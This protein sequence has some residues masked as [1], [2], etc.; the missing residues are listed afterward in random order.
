MSDK[1]QPKTFK[2]D[3]FIMG[4]GGISALISGGTLHPIDTIKV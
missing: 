1:K 2:D 4:L 3:L